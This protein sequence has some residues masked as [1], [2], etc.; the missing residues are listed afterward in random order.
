MVLRAP[1]VGRQ[2]TELPQFQSHLQREGPPGKGGKGWGP[3]I[4]EKGVILQSHFGAALGVSE[5]L[6]ESWSEAYPYL[7]EKSACEP[8]SELTVLWVE[9]FGHRRRAGLPSTESPSADLSQPSHGTVLA[10]GDP[11]LQSPR[12]SRAPWH[13]LLLKKGHLPQSLVH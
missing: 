1:S 2:N 11:P 5:F 9:P 10:A 8:G 6:Q 4:P 12:S 3:A 13:Y 7:G